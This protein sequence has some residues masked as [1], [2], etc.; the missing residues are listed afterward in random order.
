VLG[1]TWL[2]CATGAWAELP[3]PM[4]LS[5]RF[6]AGAQA[7]ALGADDAPV[8]VVEFVDFRCG[9]C[10]VQA[11][12]VFDELRQRYIDT[13]VVRYLAVELPLLGAE[14]ERDAL[15]VRCAG[16]QGAYWP[17]HRALLME[18]PLPRDA[19]LDL[20][21]LAGAASLDH[22]RL[23]ACLE[24]DEQLALLAEGVARARAHRVD[25]TPTFFFGFATPGENA[26]TI[27]RHL[28]GAA[29]AGPAI[30]AIEALLHSRRAQQLRD[31]VDR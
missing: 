16:A 8:V 2:V 31:R 21:W 28:V 17:A 23:T 30:E 29:G 12:A 13:G 19:P 6:E 15:A 4:S 18:A 10:A 27:E 20:G 9:Y 14:A 3:G 7:A 22:A 11:R 5:P 1:L 24:G 25:A 26:L